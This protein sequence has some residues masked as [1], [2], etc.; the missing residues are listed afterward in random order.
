M[1]ADVVTKDCWIM[2]QIAGIRMLEQELTSAFKSPSARTGEDL[3]RR[4]A[5]LNSWLNLVDDALTV[6]TGP[7]LVVLRPGHNSDG[8]PPAA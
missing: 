7:R 5:Q 4:V 8:R 1:K 3:Q 6:R 2:G